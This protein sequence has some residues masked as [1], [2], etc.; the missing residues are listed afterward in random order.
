MAYTI[1][2]RFDKI[3][4]ADYDREHYMD[5]LFK[6]PENEWFLPTNKDGDDYSICNQLQSVH[7]ICVRHTPIW[8]NGSF[9]GM[10]FEFKY[11]RNLEY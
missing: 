6:Y 9:K 8:N 1:E 7:L 10:R 2:E 3:F 11:N 4:P 5:A